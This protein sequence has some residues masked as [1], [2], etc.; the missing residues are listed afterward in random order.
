LHYS[1]A[2]EGGQIGDPNE[3]YYLQLPN[4]FG[5]GPSSN[6]PNFDP[7]QAGNDQ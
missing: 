5:A 3:N 2:A 6:L 4:T 1:D 7:F